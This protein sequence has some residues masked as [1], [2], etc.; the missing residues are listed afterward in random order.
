M[1]QLSVRTARRRW[2]VSGKCQQTALLHLA[3]VQFVADYPNR[4]SFQQARKGGVNLRRA[5]ERGQAHRCREIPKR[6]Q[7][8][9]AG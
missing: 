9:I 7:N 1:H 3:A 8:Q 6:Q 5:G 4:I 2:I